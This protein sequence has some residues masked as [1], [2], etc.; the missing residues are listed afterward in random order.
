MKEA[1]TIRR[2]GAICEITL[3][4]PKAN[5][6]NVATSHA[7]Y[8][9]FA[10][11]QQDASLRVA[12]LTGAGR[13]FSAGWD[14][15]AGEAVDAD[16]GPGGFA[17][18]TEFFSLDK[19][20][21]AAVNGLAL[22]G[23]FEL[24]LAADMIIAADNAEFALPEVALGIIADS[25]GMQRLPKR[26]PRALANELAFTGRRMDMAEASRWGL[27]NKAVSAENLMPE[28]RAL[29]A[30][31]AQ[32]APLALRAAKALMQ[33]GDGRSIQETYRFMR[34]G[35]IAVHGQM[36]HSEDALEGPRA[37]AEK[38]LPLWKGR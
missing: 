33:A 12:I 9:A 32:N 16:H 30:N 11:F 19:P 15:K 31:I 23:G 35:N 8:A 14:L 22:G 7:L 24:A 10:E 25:G 28:A 1:V 20:V 13:F 34:A 21:I 4:R 29:A 18:L 37:F 26:L 27:I 2:D 5:A 3:D 36:V 38:R 17:G 6:V